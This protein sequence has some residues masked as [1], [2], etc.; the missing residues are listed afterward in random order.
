MAIQQNSLALQLA[1]GQLG[2]LDR[3]LGRYLAL[4]LIATIISSC[5]VDYS[6]AS[7]PPERYPPTPLPPIGQPPTA[8]ALPEPSQQPAPPPT[9]QTQP[10][11]NLL[12]ASAREQMQAGQPSRAAATLERALRIAPNDPYLW[13]ELA[14][15]RLAAGEWQ[16]AIQLAN[17]SRGLAGEDGKLREKNAA[18]IT[19]ASGK[20]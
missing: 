12:L 20:M 5:G 11:S 19:A 16:Q 4:A 3:Y 8:P 7:F 10:A 1:P 13:H 18:I 14:Q 17:K 15:I 2:H 6:P 9:A